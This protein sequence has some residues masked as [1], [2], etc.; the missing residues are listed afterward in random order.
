MWFRIRVPGGR[1]VLLLAGI[2]LGQAV[3]YGACLCGWKVFLPLDVL[4][5][6]FVYLPQTPEF[7]KLVPN[8]VAKTTS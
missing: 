2:V 4:A 6:P 5:Q 1:L 3:L 8:F 7:A